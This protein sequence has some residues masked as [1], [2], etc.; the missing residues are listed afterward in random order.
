MPYDNI[1][2]IGNYSSKLGFTLSQVFFEDLGLRE[3]IQSYAK[4]FAKML[5]GKIRHE[6]LFFFDT[7]NKREI[8]K[9]FL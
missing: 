5:W 6:I 8:F 3:L 4:I 7:K 2:N 9:L 1:G